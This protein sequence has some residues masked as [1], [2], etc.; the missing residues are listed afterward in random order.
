M[1][2]MEARFGLLRGIGRMAGV[3][4]EVIERMEDDR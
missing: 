1:Y 4:V 3:E 2:E